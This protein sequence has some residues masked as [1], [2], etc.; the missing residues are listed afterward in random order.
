M[1]LSYCSFFSFK[2]VC[3]PICFRNLNC[4]LLLNCITC[5]RQFQKT[6]ISLKNYFDQNHIPK[7][8]PHQNCDATF[9]GNTKSKEINTVFEYLKESF[10]LTR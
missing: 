6:F 9:L 10:C 5:Y 4:I 2:N 8:N 3:H 7:N 1:K